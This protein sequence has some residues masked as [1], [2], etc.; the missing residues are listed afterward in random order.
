MKIGPGAGGPENW[1]YRPARDIDV[2]L[3]HSIQ[4]ASGAYPSAYLIIT[5]DLSGGS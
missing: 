4:S 5:G 2:S 1:G 3:L